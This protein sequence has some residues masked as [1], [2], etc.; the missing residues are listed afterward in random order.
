M[1]LPEIQKILLSNPQPTQA[2]PE[3]LMEIGEYSQVLP[4]DYLGEARQMADSTAG[5]MGM[6][7]PYGKLPLKKLKEMYEKLRVDFERQLKLT[8][9]ADPIERE[10]AQKAVIKIKDKAVEIKKEIDKRQ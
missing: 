5:I 9:N 10:A 1:D 6:A 8:K 7:I 2:P 4:R 3:Y